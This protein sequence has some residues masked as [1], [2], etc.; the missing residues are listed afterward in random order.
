MADVKFYIIIP[1]YN[2]FEKIKNAIQSVLQQTYDNY[3]I[4]IVDDHSNDNNYKKLK[5]YVDGNDKISYY[6]MDKNYG[7]SHC[8]NFGV[9]K[10]LDEDSWIK[11]LDDD[12]IILPD[13]LK[14]IND[15]LNNRNCNVIT[16]S[17]KIYTETD[18]KIVVPNYKKENVFYG[19]LDTCCICHKKSLFTKLGGWDEELYRMADDDFFFK[20]IPNG[21]YDFCDKITALYYRT[22]DKTRVTNRVPN[23]KFVKHIADKYDYFNK[24]CLIKTEEKY[25]DSINSAEYN[26]ESF[27][28]FDVN[29][30]LTNEY[31]FII[32]INDN[33]VIN[34]IFQ[35]YWKTKKKHFK[36]KNSLF[37][38][39]K[40][41]K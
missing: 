29:K 30:K 32:M 13:C 21:K 11:Y 1:T 40:L 37:I 23:L 19:N 12:N 39:N 38:E 36:I 5:E 8:R 20:Y 10:V 2:R 9:N 33:D 3:H 15:F 18:S 41:K 24:K 16:T 27:M 14:D 28:K 31:N 35:Y 26:I 7:H 17:F 22:K 6:Y 4:I 25:I 34:E